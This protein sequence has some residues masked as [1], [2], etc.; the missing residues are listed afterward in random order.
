MTTL[1]KI[2]LEI[3]DYFLWDGQ[4]IDNLPLYVRRVL[5]II[6]KYAEQE[7]T[8]DKCHY[9]EHDFTPYQGNTGEFTEQEPKE[10]EVN[11]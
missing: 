2:K 11:K 10:S 7:P 3:L 9:C 6:E 8:D 1:E 5:N 4:S